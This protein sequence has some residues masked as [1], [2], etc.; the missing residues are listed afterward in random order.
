M[1]RTNK[2]LSVLLC[3][4]LI[5]SALGINAVYAEEG[6]EIT[7]VTDEH[8]S[9]T[10]YDTQDLTSGGTENAISAIAKNSDTGEIDT[11]GSG[12]VNFIVALDSGYSVDSI[13]VSGSYKN[14]KDSSDTGV[15]NGYRITK[16][17]SDL[18]VTITTKLSSEEDEETF[19]GTIILN[20]TSIDVSDANGATA[21]GS[22]VTISQAG[23]YT[24]VGSLSDGQI[25]VALSDKSEEVT[26]NFNSVTVTS[27]TGNPINATK[28]S[29]TIARNFVNTEL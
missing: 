24:I 21:D 9:V 2:L 14:L 4:M 6:Y 25:V 15:E 17:S 12:Q 28:G 29:V 23:E 1:K 8:S 10:V 5:F 7:F 22:T 18:T 19:G 3:V 20:D 13:M 27:L 16:V 11:S 26:L